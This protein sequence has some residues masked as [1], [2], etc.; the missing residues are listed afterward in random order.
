MPA[1]APPELH[2]RARLN[3][4]LRRRVRW[5]WQVTGFTISRLADFAAIAGCL[6]H[7]RRQGMNRLAVR[8]STL[9]NEH[10]LS[11]P[12]RLPLRAVK[13]QVKCNI[14]ILNLLRKFQRKEWFSIVWRHGLECLVRLRGTFLHS[15]S[16][17]RRASR[18]EI[19]RCGRWVG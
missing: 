2:L 13:Q 6:P 12:R 17:R 4:W 1:T 10:S 3:N 18:G 16:Q 11:S 9:K 7:G 15:K 8:R 5:C 14:R 19:A